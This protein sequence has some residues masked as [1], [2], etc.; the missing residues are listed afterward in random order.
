[1]DCCRVAAVL[2]LAALLLATSIC[3]LVLYFL[4]K[5]TNAGLYGTHGQLSVS[6]LTLISN[7]TILFLYIGMTPPRH[8]LVIILFALD[9]ILGIITFAL[10]EVLDW[11]ILI[12][13]QPFEWTQKLTIFYLIGLGLNSACV[14]LN[15]VGFLFVLVTYGSSEKRPPN[16]SA[17]DSDEDSSFITVLKQLTDKQSQSWLYSKGRSSTPK[18]KGNEVTRAKI[19]RPS[20]DLSPFMPEIPIKIPRIQLDQFQ[21]STPKMVA[22][23]QSPTE[24]QE[25]CDFGTLLIHRFSHDQRANGPAASGFLSV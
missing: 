11:R 20:E 17:F 22:V 18:S 9:T 6:I 13:S 25:S 23:H 7:S 12:A 15:A 2:M 24:S 4:G 14:A 21:S 16:D 19:Y 1:M 5:F 10:H 3:Q 8:R